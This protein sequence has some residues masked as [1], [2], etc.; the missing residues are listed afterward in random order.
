MHS[1]DSSDFEDQDAEAARAFG[2]AA[3]QAGVGQIIYLGGL[4]EDDSDL[5]AHLRSRREVEPLLGEAGC[6]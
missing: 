1:L 6:R 5:S 4:G 3:A 2:A